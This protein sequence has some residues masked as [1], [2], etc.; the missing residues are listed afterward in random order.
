L[1]KA[2]GGAIENIHKDEL[3]LAANQQLAAN[4]QQLRA[5]NQQ[6]KQY[7]EELEA[8][9]RATLNMMED[10]QEQSEKLKESQT[11]LKNI[12]EN[13]TNL[14]YMHT[15]EHVL[16]YVSPQV[17]HYLGY[18][19]KE[20]MKRWTEFVTDNPINQEG[21]KLTEKAIKTGK[22]QPTYEL[23][24]QRRDGVKILVEVKE[25]PL[26]ENGKVVG[27]VGSLSD[28]TGRR[29][30]ETE[31]KESEQ[32][33]QKML[34]V[35]PDMIS[36]QNPNMN[37]LYSNWQ[38]FAA[39]PPNKRVLNTK[40]YKTYR[41]FDDI[42]PD[43]LAG[44]I[45]KTKKALH[46][47][48]KLPNGKYYDIRVIP[49]LDKD[50]NVEMFME[51][52]RDITERK[53]AED[54][55]KESES[56]YRTIFNSTGTVT[57][58]VRN[59]TYIEMA[60]SEAERITGFTGSELVGSKWTDH[61]TP[62][63]LEKMMRY[64]KIRRT[65]PEEVP[66][67]YE[68]DL[69]H[70][71]GEIRR[72]L[73]TI[74]M[75]PNS[76]LSIVTLI[77]ISER[78][79][80][81]QKLKESEEKLT[82]AQ[83]IAEL[84]NFEWN[85]QTEEIY[86]SSLLYQIHGLDPKETV[87]SYEEFIE[88]VHK[89]DRKLVKECVTEALETGKYLCEYRIK[90]FDTGEIRYLY[91][92][93][94]IEYD[95]KGKPLLLKA[96]EQD[97]TERKQAQNRI[98]ASEKRYRSLYNSIRDA[99]LV[100]DTNR[101]IIDC[102]LA[103]SELFGY[104][105]EDIYEKKTFSVY[106]YEEEF[107]AMDKAIKAH[108][109]KH[110]FLYNI[111]YKKK[112]GE[113]FLGETS[114]YYMKAMD[115]NV[116][117][118]MGLIRDVTEQEKYKNELQLRNN[119]MANSI[120][121]IAI[122]N[123]KEE[124]IYLTDSHVRIYGYDSQE[125]LLGK[126]WR[127]LYNKKELSR[128]NNEIM[129]QFA[130]QGSWRG[131]ATGLKKDGSTF[132]QEISLTAL[133]NGGMVCLVRDISWR[134]QMEQ[135]IKATNKELSAVLAAIPDL[136]FIFNK[137]G[138]IMNCYAHDEDLLYE[139]KDM[140]LNQDISEILPADIAK[141]TKQKIKKVLTTGETI[142][143]NYKLDIQ[144]KTEYFESRMVYVDD[145]TTLAIS[146]DISSQVEAENKLHES[147]EKYRLLAETAT[148]VIVIHDMNGKINYANQAA[149]DFMKISKTE[150][151]QKNITELISETNKKQMQSRQSKR[152]KGDTHSFLYEIVLKV[153]GK[154]KFLEVSSS[155]LIAR[156]GSESILIVARDISERKKEEQLQQ[157]Q[158]NI[159][160][161]AL[162]AQDLH[163]LSA[164][165]QTNL[166]KIIDA[167]NF[168][169]AT[170]DENKHM[171]SFTYKQ[172]QKDD[173]KNFSLG[174]SL[175]NYVITHKKP[176]LANYDT[177]KK[178]E[179]KGEIK[180]IGHPAKIWLGIPLIYKEKVVGIMS[181]QS[182]EN[183]NAY[184]KK[185]INL[186]QLISNQL[187][188]VILR[189]QTQ[190][191][192][193]NQ[194]KMLTKAQQV[195]HL[196]SWEMDIPTGNTVWSDEFFRILG[197]E[198]GSLQPTA[199]K[200]MQFIHPE[201][202]DRAAAAVQKAIKE[203]GDYN[204]EKRIVRPNGEVRWVV[205]RGN[206]MLNKK[207]EAQILSGSFLDI[208]ERKNYELQLRHKAK[209]LQLIHE[210]EKQVSELLEPKE[211]LKKAT[212]LISELFGF[213]N[214]AILLLSENSTKLKIQAA[215]G[216][217]A[218]FFMKN[219]NIPITEGITGWV[220]RNSTNAI[221]NDVTKD[222]RFSNPSDTKLPTKS[223]L[224]IPLTIGDKTWG[225]LDC[226]SSQK[227]AFQTSDM[228][229]LQTLA[230]QI[231]AA[232]EN[233]E[234]YQKTQQELAERYRIQQALE[235]SERKARAIIDANKEIIMMLDAD[236]TILDL[237]K[238]FLKLIKR[239]NSNI[240]TKEDVLGMNVLDLVTDKNK[241]IHLSAF[242]EALS[243]TK[244]V[245][246]NLAIFN[247]NYEVYLYP[248][249]VGARKNLVL[250][251]RD[252]TKSLR[253]QQLRT[254]IY[255]I[256]NAVNETEDLNELFQKIREYLGKVIDTKNFYVAMYNAERDTISLPYHEDVKDEVE[257]F[258]A[259]KTL[260]AYVL[261]Q[262][263]PVFV[264]SKDILELKKKGLIETIGAPSK[265]WMGIPLR[266]EKQII[267]VVAVQSYEDKNAYTKK[268]RDVLEFV[269]DQIAM[270]IT[271]KQNQEEL[272]NTYE[273]LKKL[274]K[275]LEDKVDRTVNELR[276][277]DHLLIKQSRQAAMGEMIGNIAHQWRQPLTAVS[278]IV[279][280]IEDAWEFD[281][282]DAKYLNKS[283][284]TAMDQLQF[285]SRTIDDF[286][287]FFKPNKI[288]AN[289][290]AKKIVEK[291][292]TFI[293]KSFANNQIEVETKLEEVTIFG[294]ENEYSQVILNIL[295]NAKD[296]IL[297]NSKNGGTVSI[298]LTKEN[299]RGT[300]TICDTGGG[301]PQKDLDKIFDPYYTTKE[302]GKGTGIGLYM[303]KMIIENNMDG[304]IEAYNVKDGACFK[305]TV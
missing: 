183:E 19:P 159:S 80:A 150:L 240:T 110:P 211:L 151:Y 271:K 70:K 280:D 252:I 57:M 185:D 278:A 163:T 14:F 129:P 208:T 230:G 236:F 260:T 231:A 191:K 67:Q 205:S 112:N 220:A 247:R 95:K 13:S 102:N 141:L 143:Y 195:A 32:R 168:M 245:T 114:V 125:E 25:A 215:S 201:D 28:I 241:Q 96:T 85:L 287:N 180:I 160:V 258:P 229:T 224:S 216:K 24:L 78:Y 219:F 277:R 169:I 12:V 257:E 299:G 50:N 42:C 251:A 173:Y 184:D 40:C 59:D 17:H 238:E 275:E 27:I 263:K 68:V 250:S 4:E 45:L 156:D 166:N 298:E 207:G 239:Q 104:S 214:V 249:K 267:G 37:I 142:T 165:I 111:H 290:M 99:I 109:F 227:N 18:E 176:L 265:V 63:S 135:Q 192:L 186:L 51:W 297:E 130:Q 190:S 199:E 264:Q 117:G 188:N 127:V 226:Q 8:A 296:A 196:G 49:I 139:K 55:L 46:K 301:I 164:A 58:L 92:V 203:K 146:R 132:P 179:A 232:L 106:A 209:Q 210:I 292:V 172:N 113:L 120:D 281:E 1:A 6:L 101:K 60:N 93:G 119:A 30:A 71:S 197:I 107:K 235:T 286:R 62:Y 212:S 136:M 284:T 282:L 134:K 177:V 20:A 178:L 54:K 194:Q 254:V 76:Q 157:I 81:I 193:K 94:K 189:Q 88:H 234:L 218:N 7:A 115:G 204:I 283:V 122:L 237:N 138:L 162:K 5:S 87:P 161:A 149:A 171:L 44:N 86:W 41:N 47:E 217:L 293:S 225:V 91:T 182:Y 276:K 33:F 233:A 16:T 302:Q 9:Q 213:E 105:L 148:E 61:V 66:N 253:E 56:K 145:K 22:Q 2:L 98:L 23:E 108:D 38:G 289:F 74:G 84:G 256:S 118:F 261:H 69:I 246:Y 72:T 152:K 198:P 270:A 175:T 305:I 89:D 167:R 137:D 187:A 255:N 266:V 26:V 97:I 52:V 269:S 123:D 268:D 35:V 15:P 170:Y 3:F 29:E 206:I 295:N 121:G 116:T 158:A 273:Q 223:E 128:F 200:G 154:E 242:K 294:F 21:L 248:I 243:K 228:E 43:C 10:A 303:S 274:N 48:T 259:G 11:K 64:H 155:P 79:K 300:L 133:E 272:R 153:E 221:V 90:R 34:S 181:I 31:L 103:F 147:E 288:K 124:Y 262:N 304:K 285:M 222:K 65:N 82:E 144:G 131:E 53:Q 126:T 39:V 83:E 77:D 202:R 244:I 291:T 100:A 36:I 75:I 279:Q 73:L 174:K 140:I